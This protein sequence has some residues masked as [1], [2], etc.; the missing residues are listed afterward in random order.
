M[1]KDISSNR[2]LAEKIAREIFECG[3]EPSRQGGL[4]QRIQYM[5]GTYP[6][7]EIVLGGLCERALADV[8]YE[9]LQAK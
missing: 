1:N 5:G 6:D 3:S 9:T 4:V 7:N 2:A 8:I